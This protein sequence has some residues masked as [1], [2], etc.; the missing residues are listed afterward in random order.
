MRTH[1]VF[2]VSVLP[3]PTDGLSPADR[4]RLAE[5]VV[6]LSTWIVLAVLMTV[7]PLCT[8][9]FRTAALQLGYILG[10]PSVLMRYCGCKR[11]FP[12]E[13]R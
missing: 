9:A 4:L 6:V 13:P 10:V 7:A 11:P 1:D 12:C 8:P 5:E 2:L 3:C